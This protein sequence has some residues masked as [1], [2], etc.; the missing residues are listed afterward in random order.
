[1]LPEFST[2]KKNNKQATHKI[3]KQQQTTHKIS[4]A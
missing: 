4:K 3:S 2:L 1:M